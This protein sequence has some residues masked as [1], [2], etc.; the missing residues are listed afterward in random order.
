MAFFKK[1]IVQFNKS[2]ALLLVFPAFLFGIDTGIGSLS[3]VNGFD[4]TFFSDKSGHPFLHIQY[5]DAISV[6]PKIG[7]LKFGISFLKVRNL[8]VS[9]DLRQTTYQ[10]LHA[11]LD[12]LASKRSIRY[13][14]I[15][16]FSLSI[17][18]QLGE[19]IDLN[20]T[21][22]KFTA[23]GELRLWGDVVLV[24][25]GLE[26]ASSKISILHE[27]K[28]NSLNLYFDKNKDEPLRIYFPTNELSN[29]KKS[30]P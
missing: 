16:P 15:Q 25:N 2:L 13:A 22:A 29:L 8:R 11:K 1:E 4:S 18:N 6:R 10:S 5:Q 24:Q 28:T 30:N 17:I 14:T 12:Q 19:M 23:S 26:K 27:Q 3:K 21:Q 9:L 20:A 7:F